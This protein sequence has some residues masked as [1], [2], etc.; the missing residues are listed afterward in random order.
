MNNFKIYAFLLVFA[1]LFLQCIKIISTENLIFSNGKY[2]PKNSQIPFS[3]KTVS[4][5]PTKEIS[6]EQIL[7][8]GIPKISYYYGYAHELVQEI[9]FFDLKVDSTFLDNILNRVV[10]VEG[11]E[12]YFK[13]FWIYFIIKDKA[14]F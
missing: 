3:G 5:F 12:G 4:Y 9:R 14:D 13:T 10:F 1:F 7:E 6:E 11:T 2:Y 8:N